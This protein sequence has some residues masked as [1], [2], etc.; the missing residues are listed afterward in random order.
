MGVLRH[1]ELLLPNTRVVAAA[2]AVPEWR[3]TFEVI[4]PGQWWGHV[5][6]MPRC[7]DDVNSSTWTAVR[8]VES[9]GM[10]VAARVSPVIDDAAI[11]K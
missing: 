9:L 5:E 10:P 3:V 6:M 4:S 1:I 2:Q 8:D 7:G 11:G